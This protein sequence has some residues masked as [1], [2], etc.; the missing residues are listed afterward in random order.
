MNK[1][2]LVVDDEV[3]ITSTLATL[4]EVTLDC[5]VITYNS[6]ANALKDELL[7]QNKVDMVISDFMMP[8]INGLELLKS[9]KEISTKSI[10]I[11]LTG[12][13]DKENAIKCINELGLYYYLEKPWDNGDL[14]K[15]IENGFEKRQLE[16]DL[17]HKVI[18][19]EKSNH[20]ISRLYSM[21]KS[22][23]GELEQA[24]AQRNFALQS[25][26]D[27]VGQGFLTFG[28]GITVDQEYSSECINI[29]GR[30]IE[31]V[32]FPD[33]IYPDNSEQRQFLEEILSEILLEEDP[34]KLELYLPLLPD[35]VVV[36]N[37]NIIFDYKLITQEQ[38]KYLRDSG[39]VFMVVLTDITDK[40]RLESKVEEE[41]NLLK[42]V[43]EAV[44]NYRDLIDTIKDYQMFCQQ[45]ICEIVDC[46]ETL[47]AK[48][49]QLYRHVHTFKGTFGQLQLVHVTKKLHDFEDKV[50]DFQ[51]DIE[52]KTIDDLKMLLQ[53]YTLLSFL[54]E[55]LEILLKYL[56]KDFIKQDDLLLIDKSSIIA[57]EKKVLDIFPKAE[58]ASV[59]LDLHQLRYKPFKELLKSYSAYVDKLSGRLNKPMNPLVIDGG[60]MFVDSDRYY[61][62]SK[63]LIHVFRNLM[64]H[65]IETMEERASKG[66]PYSGNVIC[67]IEA[68]DNMLNL[69]ISDDG[70]GI[71]ISTVRQ[72]ALNKG[73]V[74]QERV[75]EFDDQ[76]TLALIFSDG[77]STVE[78]ISDL[79][80]R[81]MGLAAVE[82]EAERLGGH[83]KVKTVE[84]KGTEF[85]FSIPYEEASECVT[86]TAEML[87]KPLTK[88]TIDFVQS[89]SGVTMEYEE[90]SVIEPVEN[91][92]LKHMSATIALKGVLSGTF[93]VTADKE[94]LKKIASGFM[95]DEIDMSE[96]DVYFQAVLA[97]Y[98]NTILGNSIKQIMGGES[99]LS[100]SAPVTMDSEK[101]IV[102]YSESK[103]WSCNLTSEHGDLIISFI[104]SDNIR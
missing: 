92:A 77:F 12:Y 73:I 45:R 48:V 74:T 27:N 62:F 85:H 13:A 33:L 87:L 78:N 8:E 55:D 39:K 58:A 79:A 23:Y 47:K 104:T 70:A 28:N 20:E 98:I 95:M 72:K 34:G 88:S 52:D 94:I 86:I 11:L 37:R 2:I 19:L 46:G 76:Q 7:A 101:S 54:D 38:T 49:V 71:N 102:T 36:N 96:E 64:H 103:I 66:K 65:G 93:A 60:E 82:Q 22:D 53:R 5:N 26:L 14:I 24:V 51:I 21:L 6:P 40:R 17:D 18:E 43:V 44:V 80:G 16:S 29:F 89:Y 50:C 57:I 31:N 83:V 9:V 35:E 56:G 68:V 42:M 59:L 25:I 69:V 84:G 91:L 61:D 97:E 75:G 67:R 41:K 3:L 90:A 1:T 4:L 30:Q 99:F 63:S 81:G 100:I 32:S 15:I 10:N